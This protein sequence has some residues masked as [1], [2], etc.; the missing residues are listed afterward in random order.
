MFSELAGLPL[1]EYI[2]RRQLTLAG[3]EVLSQ[4]GL[5]AAG[6]P[7]WPAGGLM[8]PLGSAPRLR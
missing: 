3:A 8:L 2:R 5:G 4:E 7:L 6:S 1:S